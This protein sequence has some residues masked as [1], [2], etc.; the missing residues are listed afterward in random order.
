MPTNEPQSVKVADAPLAAIIQQM[1]VDIEDHQC[2]YWLYANYFDILRG[3][4]P[5]PTDRTAT[6]W[7]KCPLYI[8]YDSLWNPEFVED[9]MLFDVI[10]K[11]KLPA[12][13]ERIR[14]E[15]AQIYQVKRVHFD[16]EPKPESAY[17]IYNNVA[18]R[19]MPPIHS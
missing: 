11:N 19:Q 10:L 12:Q 7:W 15:Y 16:E 6:R 4:P 9:G 14:I 1:L 8:D 18:K 5:P 3:G 17:L 2:C 13:K